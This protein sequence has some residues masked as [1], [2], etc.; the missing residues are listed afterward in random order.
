M[1]QSDI[2][3]RISEYLA[4]HSQWKEGLDKLRKILDKSELE[5]AIKWGAPIYHL[6]NKN[7]VGLLGFKNHFC[8]WFYQGVFL[9]D[10][11]S[12]LINAQEGKTKAMRHLRFKDSNEV[13]V[14]IVTS[15]VKEAILNQKNGKEIKV[16]RKSPAFKLAPELKENFVKSK[17]LKK[18]FDKLSPAKQKEFSNYISTA[19]REETKK[20]RL[21][22]I[23]P[24]I[25]T[26]KPIY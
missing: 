12:L 1:A 11:K 10:E 14:R 22:K 17:T 25:K 5:P 13:N 9:K 23:I 3:K 15:Y 2:N 26:G 4:K 8:L 6:N 7:V 16:V 24:L 18:A 20:R 19:K 21:Q